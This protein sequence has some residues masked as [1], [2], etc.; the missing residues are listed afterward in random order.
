MRGPDEQTQHIFSYLSPEQRV[1][2]DH[3]LRAIRALTDDALRSMSPQF[4]QLVGH[5]AE[6]PRLSRLHVMEHVDC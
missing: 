2:A 4:A 3:P 5:R 1:P 6:R